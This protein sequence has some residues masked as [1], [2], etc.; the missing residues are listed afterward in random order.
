M[1][2]LFRCVTSLSV[3]AADLY[4]STKKL[5][6]CSWK[7]TWWFFSEL[8]AC[9]LLCWHKFQWWRKII[10]RLQPVGCSCNMA[11]AVCFVNVFWGINYMWHLGNLFCILLLSEA[12][13]FIYFWCFFLTGFFSFTTLRNNWHLFIGANLI[14]WIYFSSDCSLNVELMLV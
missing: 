5:R 12:V 9:P 6:L 7:S 8:K 14:I 11:S 10:Y 1:L 13:R 2:L 3:D 4:L